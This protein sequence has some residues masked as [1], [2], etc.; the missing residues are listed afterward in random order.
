MDGV[1]SSCWPPASLLCSK[2]E[3]TFVLYIS[4]HFML[5]VTKHTMVFCTTAFSV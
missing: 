3:G 2:D 1:G 4:I 5:S